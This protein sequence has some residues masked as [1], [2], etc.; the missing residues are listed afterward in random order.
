LRA[1]GNFY[2]LVGI[3]RC[4]KLGSL[5]I[6][7][8]KTDT[9]GTSS[10]ENITLNVVATAFPEFKVTQIILPPAKSEILNNSALI[11]REAAQLST[12]VNKFT[13]TRLWSGTFR[14]PISSIITE[15]FGTRR[16]YNGG[17]VG[18]CGHEGTDFRGAMGDPVYSDARGRVV[19]AALT[20]V[21]GNLVVVDHGIGVF[22]AYF[23]MSE[24]AVHEGDIVE[25]GDVIGKVGNLGI[26]TGPHLHWSMWVA[27]EY[28][29]PMEWTKKV[30]P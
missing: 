14:Q 9:S 21:R 25:S 15:Y 7:L 17:P 12:V 11:A 19:F 18:A 20:Q 27:G 24:I 23:H 6:K 22:S 13:T 28:V 2:A 1:S 5:P 8:T 3:S 4:A 10:T 30:F 16:S 29:D 26:S